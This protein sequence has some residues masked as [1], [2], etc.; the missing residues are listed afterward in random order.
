MT[1]E[2]ITNFIRQ[3]VRS[4]REQNE[5]SQD[6]LARVIEKT[7]T[8]ISD[9]ERGKV[10]ISTVDLAL[11]AQ[12]LGKPISYFFPAFHY[13]QHILEYKFEVS[14]TLEDGTVLS[15]EGRS[16]EY[17]PDDDYFDEGTIL[18]QAFESVM[19]HFYLFEIEKKGHMD[20]LKRVEI[21]ITHP[22]YGLKR[23]LPQE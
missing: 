20:K 11:I 17:L 4:A 8:T 13:D 23:S 5:L 9:I 2:D 16:E 22:Q 19:N 6:E 10:G 14:G 21:S 3:R 7:N 1:S 15:S 12:H 18:A